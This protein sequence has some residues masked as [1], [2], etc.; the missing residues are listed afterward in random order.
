MK[1]L[2]LVL[3]ILAGCATGHEP[4][5]VGTDHPA[6]PQAKAVPAWTPD[7]IR[8]VDDV[9]EIEPAEDGEPMQHGGHGGHR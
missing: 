2:V 6:N 9:P 7:A 1:A 4:E 3:L 5:P 8:A